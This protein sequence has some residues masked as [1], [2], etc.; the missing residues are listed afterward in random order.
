MTRDEPSLALV[1]QGRDAISDSNTNALS[2]AP[3]FVAPNG[4]RAHLSNAQVA[5]TPQGRDSRIRGNLH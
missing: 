2:E 4:S 3:D 5:V 1:T